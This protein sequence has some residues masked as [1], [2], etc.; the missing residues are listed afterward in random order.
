VTQG[1]NQAEALFYAKLPSSLQQQDQNLPSQNGVQ[2][3]MH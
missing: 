1:Q 3:M 2:A